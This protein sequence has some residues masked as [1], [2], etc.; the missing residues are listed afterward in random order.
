[1]KVKR[2]I[3]GAIFNSERVS[4]TTHDVQLWI[5]T[6][7]DKCGLI[8]VKKFGEQNQPLNFNFKSDNREAVSGDWSLDLHKPQP[9]VYMLY[10]RL[11]DGSGNIWTGRYVRTLEVGSRYR[12]ELDEVSGPTP[13]NMTFREL[14][15]VKEP[16]AGIRYARRTAREEMALDSLSTVTTQVGMADSETLGLIKRR[17]GQDQFRKNLLKAWDRQCAVTGCKIVDL[18]EAAHIEPHRDGHN[19]QTKNGLLLRADIHTLFDLGLISIDE[20]FCI[21]IAPKIARSEYAIL[22]GKLLMKCPKNVE[23]MPSTKA[24]KKHHNVFIERQALV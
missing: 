3:S 24:L 13:V 14:T 5:E 4:W 10:H 1:M 2:N 20:K 17:R 23:D 6:N 15:G 21:H 16:E 18:L 9:L 7:R 19:F 11:G 8:Y 22:K 12:I